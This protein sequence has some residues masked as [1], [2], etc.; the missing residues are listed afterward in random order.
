MLL[1]NI[2]A[3]LTMGICIFL[4][5]I[6][7][8]SSITKFLLLISFSVSIILSEGNSSKLSMIW[9][10]HLKIS[11]F[12]FFLPFILSPSFPFFNII[13]YYILFESFDVHLPWEVS[14]VCLCG[15]WDLEKLGNLPKVP[16]LVTELLFKRGIVWFQA[17][18]L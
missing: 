2:L 8:L 14:S 5:I 15:T 9:P 18:H 3:S 1:C 17:S 13:T 10:K 12:P 6:I 7:H 4:L 16:Q 11:F